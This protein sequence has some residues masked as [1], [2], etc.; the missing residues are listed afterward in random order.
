MRWKSTAQGTKPNDPTR[1]MISVGVRS[2]I[3]ASTSETTY[4]LP[5]GSVRYQRA[6]E[7]PLFPM[8]MTVERAVELH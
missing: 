3:E 1:D 5:F 8:E 7:S 4:F 6:K 2:V